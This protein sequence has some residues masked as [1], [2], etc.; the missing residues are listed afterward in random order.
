MIDIVYQSESVYSGFI[1]LVKVKS[2]P[3]LCRHVLAILAAPH[4]VRHTDRA[5]TVGVT[6]RWENHSVGGRG[7]NTSPAAVFLVAQRS[8]TRNRAH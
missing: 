4:S 1:S 7:R 5:Q 6:S 2:P 3:S 8:L